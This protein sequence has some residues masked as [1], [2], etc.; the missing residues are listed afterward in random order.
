MASSNDLLIGP[1]PAATD[2]LRGADVVVLDDAA[3][4][5]A[6]SHWLKS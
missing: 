5:W 1:S 6:A 2:R 3:L 4:V